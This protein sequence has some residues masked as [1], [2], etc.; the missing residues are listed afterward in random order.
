MPWLILPCTLLER[1]ARKALVLLHR[2][3]GG[4]VNATEK[5]LSATFDGVPDTDDL[6]GS[7]DAVESVVD[8]V[9]SYSVRRRVETRSGRPDRCVEW[10]RHGKDN[11]RNV[12]R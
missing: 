9:E 8:R 1:K 3:T 2:E 10:S 5:R 6:E 7:L 11:S 12:S 4:L